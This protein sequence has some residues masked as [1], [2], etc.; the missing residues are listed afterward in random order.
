MSEHGRMAATEVDLDRFDAMLFDLDG[1][2]TR[3]AT[4]HAAAWKAMFD[5]FLRS[6]S[7]RHGDPFVPFDIATDYVLYIDGRRRYDGVRA[8]LASRAIELPE[9]SPADG[10]DELT[11]AGLGN[12]KDHFF[13]QQLQA[14]GVEV[15]DDTLLLVRRLHAAGKPIAV[16]SASENCV[17]VLQRAGIDDLFPVRVTGVDASRLG[18]A[19][20]PAPDTFLEA[21]RRLGVPPAAAVVFEDALSGVEAGAAGGFGLVVGVDRTGTG[22][23]LLVHGADVVVTDLTALAPATS[24]N[25]RSERI[26]S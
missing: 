26:P 12:R 22:E 5:D 24:S 13:N 11:V 6:W 16:V 8:F 7:R 2:I 19:G 9:G 4:V 14:H 21:A 3:T 10:D 1:V 25:E 23:Q 18:L 17:P 20:K 15:F